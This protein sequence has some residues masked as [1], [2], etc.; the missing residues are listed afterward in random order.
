MKAG[1]N[2]R[3]VQWEMG[4]MGDV[5]NV[6]SMKSRLAAVEFSRYSKMGVKYE[7]QSNNKNLINRL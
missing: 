5:W 1:Y 7:K 3:L 4:A 2:G 6:S